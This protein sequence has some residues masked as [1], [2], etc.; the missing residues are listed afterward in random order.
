MFHHYSLSTEIHGHRHL[1]IRSVFLPVALFLIYSFVFTFCSNKVPV[2]VLV[3]QFRSHLTSVYHLHCT[4]SKMKVKL[5]LKGNRSSLIISKRKKME[6]NYLEIIWKRK[7]SSFHP[8]HD[9]HLTA[10]S[11]T[12]CS[13]I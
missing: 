11:S 1:H 4:I 3:R 5:Y 13:S 7:R 2:L 6:K 9:M 12:Y 8:L 10:V